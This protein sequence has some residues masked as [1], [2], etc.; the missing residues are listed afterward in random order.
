MELINNEQIKIKA[1]YD[2][3]INDLIELVKFMHNTPHEDEPVATLKDAIKAYA[4][5]C[6]AMG[7]HEGKQ[8]GFNQA[9]E[10][11]QSIIK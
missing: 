11:A 1:Q 3:Q 9:T 6:Y 8:L 5:Y 7:V 10:L 4:E 2:S